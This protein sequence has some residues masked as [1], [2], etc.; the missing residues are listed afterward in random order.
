MQLAEK[1]TQR[2]WSTSSSPLVLSDIFSKTNSVAIWERGFNSQVNRYFQLAFQALGLGIRGVFSMDSLEDE[3]REIMPD[4]EGMDAAITDIHLLS[5]MLT[6]LFDCEKVGLRLAPLSTAMCPKFHVDNI[7]VRLVSTY[8]GPGTEWLPL[9]V[10]EEDPLDNYA[11][12]K[13]SGAG[14]YSNETHVQQMNTFDVG[15]LKGKAWSQHEEM[16]ALHRSCQLAK[17]DKRLLLTLDPM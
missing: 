17:D 10:L 1:H 7:P 4:C 8:V 9:E 2:S 13:K 14:I 15:L 11:E 3:L 12:N 16:A 6:C 5:D